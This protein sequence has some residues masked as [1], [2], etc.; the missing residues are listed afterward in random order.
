MQELGRGER[1]HRRQG[2]E[3]LLLRLEHEREDR[4]WE[5]ERLELMFEDRAWGE[6]EEEKRELVRLH[7]QLEQERLLHVDTDRQYEQE[8]LELMFEPEDPQEIRRQQELLEQR[9]AQDR[10]DQRMHQRLGEE[11][12][13]LL[14]RLDEEDWQRSEQADRYSSEERE[15][16]QALEVSNRAPVSDRTNQQIPAAR[17]NPISECLVCFDAPR[18]AVCVPCGHVSMCMRCAVHVER[19]THQCIVCRASIQ[20][21]VRIFY[22]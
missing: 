16:P 4:P 13:E 9:L 18:N 1:L 12:L 8:R 5:R 2:Q 17:D 15:Q 22:A 10:N 20:S 11:R 14:F 6:Q 3:R 19:S 21:I 7:Q